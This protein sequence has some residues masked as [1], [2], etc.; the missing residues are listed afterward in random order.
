MNTGTKERCLLYYSRLYCPVYE[1]YKLKDG[2]KYAIQRY[3]SLK[4]LS[5]YSIQP[6][7]SDYSLYEFG[8]LN[9]NASL[10]QM[11]ESVIE[12]KNSHRNNS[13]SVGDVIKIYQTGNP[14][15]FYVDPVGLK[16]LNTF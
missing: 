1:Q 14:F 13:V 12:R 8:V 7:N 6:V 15:L 16:R 3:C 4:V 2:A 5:E 9:A 10:E 11:V